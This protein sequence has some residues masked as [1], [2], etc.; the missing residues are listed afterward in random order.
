VAE[1]GS[2]SVLLTVLGE[3]LIDLVPNGAPGGYHARPGGSPFNVAVGL[4]RLGHRTALMARLADNAF[5]RQLRGHAAG[6]G[7]E[8]GHA[9]H[10]AEPTTL[11]IVSLDEQAQATYDFYLDGTAD[12]QWTAA[13]AAD[14]PPGTSVLH[15]GSLASW[16][17]PG[18]D[19]VHAVAS[20]LHAE[21]RV[22]ISYDPNIRPRLLPG[23]QAAR[24]LIERYVG[25]AHVVKASLDDIAWLYPGDEPDTVAEHWL[26]L[27]APVVVV[28]HGSRGATLH[29]RGGAIHRPG[30]VIEV[31]DTVGAG[32]AFTAGL[33]S[34]L[35][36]RGVHDPAT[37]RGSSAQLLTAALDDA[38]L[39]SALTCQR[40]GADPP[41]AAADLQ[42]APARPLSPADLRF[43]D[44][45]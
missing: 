44:L 12:W 27:G 39:V 35:A 1:A 29:R 6:A 20:G 11:A 28:T 38:I 25:V 31:V 19:H 2:G 30:R 45:P 16:T 32:D 14:L 13:E 40:A 21:D 4:A 43:A 10:A 26:A 9:P 37:L 42:A 36:R 7:L 23:P 18:A 33:L 24:P 15:L 3:A 5:G 8:L 34:A 17:A 22:L 41:Y